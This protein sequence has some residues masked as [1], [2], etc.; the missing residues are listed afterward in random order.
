MRA[1]TARK[2]KPGDRVRLRLENLSQILESKSGSGKSN[3]AETREWLRNNILKTGFVNHRVYS[4]HRIIEDSH[5]VYA[6]EIELSKSSLGYV[7]THSLGAYLF[8]KVR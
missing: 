7:D 5:Q 4:V 3:T 1:S 6:I 8:E 2:L